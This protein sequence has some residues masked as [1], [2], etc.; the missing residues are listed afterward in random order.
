MKK[1]EIIDQVAEYLATEAGAD[2]GNSGVKYLYRDEADLLLKCL[3]EQ[4][5]RRSIHL[6]QLIWHLLDDYGVNEANRARFLVDPIAYN[7]AHP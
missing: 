4:R 1:R 5:E 6:L 2:Y 3:D 7:E